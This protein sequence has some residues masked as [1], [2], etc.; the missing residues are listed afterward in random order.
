MQLAVTSSAWSYIIKVHYDFIE[1]AQTLQAVSV[2]A[3]LVV[4]LFELR[5]RC[6]QYTYAVICL[7][8]QVLKK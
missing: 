4:K 1:E 2:G 3:A 6:E 7:A 5:H 8:V